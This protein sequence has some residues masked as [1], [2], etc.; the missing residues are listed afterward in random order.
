MREPKLYREEYAN[1]NAAFPER[2][3]LTIKDVAAYIGCCPNTAKKR[4]PF[5]TRQTGYAGCTKAQLARA[6]AEEVR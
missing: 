5:I 6:L 2:S 3:Y 1:I 4:Y